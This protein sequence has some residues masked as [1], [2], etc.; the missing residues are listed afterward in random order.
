[1]NNRFILLFSIAFISSWLNAYQ[2]SSPSLITPTSLSPRE[3][4]ITLAHR[5][6]GP[7]NEKPLDTFFGMNAGAN[8]SLSLRHNFWKT[9]E[10]KA[11]YT[12]SGKQY[13]LGAAYRFTPNDFP[14]QAQLDYRYFS[15]IQSTDS[16]RHGNFLYLV[17]AQTNPL[18][19]RLI[20]TLNAGYD[21]YYERLVSG[22]GLQVLITE[23]LSLLGEYYPVWDRNSAAD[24]LKQYIGKDD[25]FCIALKADTY[26]HH[27]I[28]SLGNASGMDPRIQSLGTDNR[29]LHLGFNIQRRLGV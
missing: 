11:G 12:R 26:G 17:S 20:V 5:F 14:V 7:V 3:S 24:V 22:A 4:E 6:Y 25:A 29:D 8:V 15:F 1:M 2:N 28:F 23:K 10:A 21:G 18:A 13:E 19:E 9:L 16:K 27:F